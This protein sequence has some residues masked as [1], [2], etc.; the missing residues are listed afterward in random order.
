MEGRKRGWSFSVIT[1][2]NTASLSQHQRV[3]GLNINV[4]T[5]KHTIQMRQVASC[6]TTTTCSCWNKPRVTG[7]GACVPHDRELTS[8]WT[9]DNSRI[10]GADGYIH[11]AGAEQEPPLS[12]SA[13]GQAP[14]RPARLSAAPPALPFALQP[15]SYRWISGELDG[16]EQ[17]NTPPPPTTSSML[18]PKRRFYT[19]NLFLGYLSGSKKDRRASRRLSEQRV[20]VGAHVGTLATRGDLIGSASHRGVFRGTHRRTFFSF[21]SSQKRHHNMWPTHPSAMT[22]LNIRC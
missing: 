2:C 16:P 14:A 12:R 17:R 13:T 21:F 10:T 22:T 8:V 6:L 19:R 4:H 18:A 15:C 20:C 11:G 5:V 1:L 7:P 3:T 9:D